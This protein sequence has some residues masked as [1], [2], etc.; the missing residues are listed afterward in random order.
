M[1][2][3]PKKNIFCQ[4]ELK[5]RIRFADAV[6]VRELVRIRLPE[7]GGSRRGGGEGV[8][9]DPVQMRDPLRI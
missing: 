2:V 3:G 9:P 7:A 4:L 1:F 6:E 5:K 8:G